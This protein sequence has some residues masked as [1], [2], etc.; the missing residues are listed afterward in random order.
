MSE[1]IKYLFDKFPS[2]ESLGFETATYN[3]GK[4]PVLRHINGEPLSMY[5]Q[6][7]GHLVVNLREELPSLL[8]ALN[9]K[10]SDMVTIIS[11]IALVK[12]LNEEDEW[13]YPS[14]T[15]NRNDYK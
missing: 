10:E 6:T 2:I 5:V 4:I 3:G 8:V 11:E 7:D 13:S 12:N 14:Y 1:K 9:L 15:I